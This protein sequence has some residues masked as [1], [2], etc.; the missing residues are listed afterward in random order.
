MSNTWEYRYAFRINGPTDV[1]PEF[2]YTH[3]QFV[4]SEGRPLFALFTPALER[5]GILTTHWLPP[6][7]ILAF[8]NFLAVLSL[9]RRSNQV[10]TFKLKR[11]DFLGCGFSNFLLNSWT[12]LYPGDSSDRFQISFPSQAFRH[13]QELFHFLLSWSK[14]APERL[15][16]CQPG[17][18]QS[19]RGLPPKFSA[20]LEG[21]PELGEAFAFFFQPAMELHN[22][23][24][25]AWANLL[26][27][28]S[29][30]GVVALSDQHHE[31]SSEYGLE[32]TFFPLRCI[33]RVNWIEPKAG[34]R[35]V[36]QTHLQGAECALRLRWPVF[37]DLRPYALRWISEVDR[38]LIGIKRHQNYT[39]ASCATGV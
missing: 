16:E 36:I 26:L 5:S 18:Q 34:N 1:P 38:L 4:T 2:T 3:E 39:G 17:P 28:I 20:V 8:R 25:D 32:T 35:A 31:H 30:R 24:E 15:F 27:A 22:R 13:H 19:I 12:S 21:Y 7:L 10:C 14:E 6:R 29:P 37:R 9:E 11:E 23:H 33:N